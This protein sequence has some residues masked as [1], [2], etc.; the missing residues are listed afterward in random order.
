MDVTS[1]YAFWWFF[2]KKLLQWGHFF[3]E[4]LSSWSNA[5]PLH[6][7][8]NFAIVSPYF[9]QLQHLWTKSIIAHLWHGIASVTYIVKQIKLTGRGNFYEGKALEGQGRA[10]GS[11]AFG[12]SNWAMWL[13]FSVLCV[14]FRGGNAMDSCLCLLHPNTHFTCG[15]GAH[16]KKNSCS[17]N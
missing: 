12:Q 16:V 3:P 1:T 4:M 11:W 7:C 9:D 2:L 17:K 15:L 14:I 6:P 8:L 10:P 13:S 5:T